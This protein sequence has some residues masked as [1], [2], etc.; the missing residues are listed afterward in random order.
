MS[1]MPLRIDGELIKEARAS[2]TVF[3]RS[4]AQQLEHWANLGKVLEGALTVRSVAHV[5][6]LKKPADLDRLLAKAGSSAG[7]KRTLALLAKK[8]G[9]LYGI[10][11]DRPNVLLQYQLDGTTVAG[12]MSRGAFVPAK[13][14][15]KVKA[16]AAR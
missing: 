6:S 13:T 14:T 10:K 16:L 12:H 15:S 9:P 11:T 4:I 5:K 8:K 7:K 1:S 3:H 2:G